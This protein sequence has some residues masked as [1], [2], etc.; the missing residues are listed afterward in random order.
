MSQNKVLSLIGLATKAGKVTSGEFSTEKSVKTGYAHLVI[1]S[2][3]ASENTKKKFRNMCD[4]YQVPISFY[5]TKDELGKA[6]GKEFRASLA[7]Q[8]AGLAKAIEKVLH[9]TS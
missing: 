5:G 8:D 2:E 7:V 9:E 3:E 4:Y 1:V 6:M